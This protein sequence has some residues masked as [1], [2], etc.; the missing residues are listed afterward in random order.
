MKTMFAASVG[1]VAAV[2]AASVD[3][4]ISESAIETPVDA[5]TLALQHERFERVTVPVTIGGTGPYRFL[6]DTGAQA[7]VLS[8][9]LADE[10]SLHDRSEATL[11]GMASRR[12]VETTTI[13]EFGLGQRQMTIRAA[14]LVERR[15]IGGAHGILGL[16]SLQDQ[17]V[18]IDFVDREIHI[19]DAEEKKSNLGYEI[20]VKAKPKLGQLIIT[21]AKVNGVKT[22]VI[23]DTGAQA[24]IGNPAL[25]ERLR[26][27]RQIGTS[28]MTDINGVSLETDVY[29]AGK[30]SFGQIQLSDFPIYFA[31]SPPF[32]ALGLAERP[33]LVLG[34]REL[35]LFRRVA[36]DFDTRRVLF[37]L[38]RGTG[39]GQMRTSTIGGF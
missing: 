16:D 26:R 24:T 31:D 15:N 9:E 4:P 25:L 32:H 2:S 1:A 35:S 11:I 13:P 27:S 5:E 38:P 8:R 7:T 20:M 33:A 14:P 30:L 28:A 29:R 3:L 22:T 17:R 12:R 23:I 18:V 19:A 36:I 10:L 21:D 6:V 37:D 34:M 39:Y